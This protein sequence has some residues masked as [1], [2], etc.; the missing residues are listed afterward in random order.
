MKDRFY[1]KT[2]SEFITGRTANKRAFQIAAEGRKCFVVGAF[3]TRDGRT[4]Y[5][6]TTYIGRREEYHGAHRTGCLYRVIVTPKQPKLRNPCSD[7]NDLRI[8]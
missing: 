4:M 2:R 3:T 6:D 5:A 7:S 1:S 8:G